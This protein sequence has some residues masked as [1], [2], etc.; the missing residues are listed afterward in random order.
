MSDPIDA[1]ALRN[2]A[3]AAWLARIR[4]VELL[5]IAALA[6]FAPFETPSILRV[7]LTGTWLIDAVCT[8]FF[9]AR[10]VTGRP[11][12]LGLL[13][14]LDA[15]LLT[16]ALAIHGGP[17]NPASAF[18]LVECAF[19]ALLLPV[20]AAATVLGATV[21]GYALL[22]FGPPPFGSASCHVDASA[23]AEHLR[24]MFVVDAFASVFLVAVVHRLRA[25]LERVEASLADAE[26]RKARHEKL[27]SLSSLAATAAH[28]LGTPLGTIRV[29]AKELERAAETLGNSSLLDDAR[30]IRAEVERCRGLLNE[31]GQRAGSAQGEAPIRIDA[32]GFGQALREILAERSLSA[33]VDVR[34]ERAS[35]RAPKVALV[36]TV[37]NLVKNAID[38]SE[39]GAASPAVTVECTLVG[40]SITVD[41]AGSGMSDEVLAQAGEPFFTTKS[42]GKGLGLGVFLARE[43]AEG[44]DGSLTYERRMPAGM[45]ATLSWPHAPSAAP[46]DTP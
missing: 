41:D 39:P 18:F 40:V 42:E 10:G 26:R 21:A 14:V 32:V 7:L 24:G 4:V 29:V 36:R 45:R 35:F 27:A 31:L 30:L 3:G 6:L 28:E 37:T 46:T 5:A 2:T 12:V 33:S 19:A 15:I 11:Q 16:F 43:L 22:L 44:L 1:R 23:Y 25:S 38:A 13:L 20:T 9:A 34:A 8:G 17:T